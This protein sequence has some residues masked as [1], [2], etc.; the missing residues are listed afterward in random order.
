MQVGLFGIHNENKSTGDTA[1]I[2]WAL[3]L[4]TNTIQFTSRWTET[5]GNVL[6]LA[7]HFPVLET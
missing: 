5:S 4:P 6:M 3:R 1:N 7:K 2:H